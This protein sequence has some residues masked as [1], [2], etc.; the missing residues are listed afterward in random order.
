MKK[1]YELLKDKL[2]CGRKRVRN[3]HENIVYR[4][5]SKSKYKHIIF[6]LEI[7]SN[8]RAKAKLKI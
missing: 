2:L 8:S 5:N 7:L 3:K 4:K 6:F 1:A